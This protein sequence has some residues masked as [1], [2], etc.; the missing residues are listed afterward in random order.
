[1]PRVTCSQGLAEAAIGT[2]TLV[3]ALPVGWLADKVPRHQVIA[4]G[5]GFS[6]LAAIGITAHAIVRPVVPVIP[7]ESEDAAQARRAAEDSAQFQQLVI[8]CIVWGIANGIRSGPVKALFADS[9]PTGSRSRSVHLTRQFRPPEAAVAAAAIS[10][11]ASANA[12][13]MSLPAAAGKISTRLPSCT[14]VC[15]M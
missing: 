14:H 9:I 8:A 12:A 15:F 3:F 5:G 7:G 13:V 6:S 1:M 2:S 10:A 4:Y 11:A